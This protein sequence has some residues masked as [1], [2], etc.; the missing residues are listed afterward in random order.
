MRTIAALSTI[1]AFLGGLGLFLYGVHMTSEALQKFSA[2]RLKQILQ[3]LTKKKV[4]AVLSGIIMTIAFQSSAATTVLVVEFVNAGLINLGQ[5]LGVVLGSA[6]GTSIIIQLIAFKF[7]VIALGAIFAGFTLYILG[8]KQWKHLGQSLIGF[9]LIFVGIAYMSDAAAPLRNIPAV[10]SFLEHL[11][12]APFMAIL[13]GLVLT[14]ALQSSTAVFAIMMS[15]ASQQLIDLSAIIPLVL[16]SHIGGTVTTL[17]SSLTAERMDAKRTAIAN[18]GYKVVATLLLFPFMEQFQ[19][20]VQWSTSDLTR[21]VANAHL[22]SALFMV[23]IFFPFN[24]WLAKGLKVLIPDRAGS[25]APFKFRFIEEAAKEVPAIALKQ[26]WEE[27]YALASLIEEQMLQKI[28]KVFAEDQTSAFEEVMATEEQVDWYYRHIMRFLSR[29]SQKGLTEEQEEESIN[30]QFILKELERIGDTF[31]GMVQFLEKMEGQNLKLTRA[32]W[33]SLEELYDN[34]AAHYTAMGQSLRTGDMQSAEEIIQE[35]P[36]VIRLQRSLQFETLAQA[37]TS[38]AELSGGSDE[39]KLR[40][41]V[42]DMLDRIY[43][44]EDNIVNI[45]QVVLGIV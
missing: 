9:G 20:L 14:A 16:G 8:K 42:L 19:T 11:G 12:S 24:N 43:S 13:V 15:M 21:Q 23:I 10:N 34:V 45:S 18:T 2:K 40:Y 6:L 33:D 26:A 30:M 39:E 1:F 22:F 7:L 5:A 36:E 4:Y 44:I 41:A 29:L 27:T 17:L 38:Q 32:E 31:V 35:R 28:A 37:G 3:S 25:K